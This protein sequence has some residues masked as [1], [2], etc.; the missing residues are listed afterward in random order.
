MYPALPYSYMAWLARLDARAKQRSRPVYWL[1]LFLKWN[2][3]V[4]GAWALTV[5][6]IEGLMRREVNI[7]VG[8]LVYAAFTGL[9]ILYRFLR[10]RV[11]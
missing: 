11:A 10:Q 9:P 6:G 5:Y 1:Y 8:F 2:L 3:V 4:I 7:G